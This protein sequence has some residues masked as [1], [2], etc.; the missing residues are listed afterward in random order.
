MTRTP[1]NKRADEEARLAYAPVGGLPFNDGLAMIRDLFKT[2]DMG[3]CDL[4]VRGKRLAA[5]TATES[6]A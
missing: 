5:A 6:A 4:I 2:D 3:A 1:T